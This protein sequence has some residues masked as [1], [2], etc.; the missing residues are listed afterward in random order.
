MSPGLGDQSRKRP[1]SS[2]SNDALH[3]PSPQRVSAN[4]STDHRPILPYLPSSDYRRHDSG[5]PNYLVVRPAE[6]MAY[7]EV[8]GEMERPQSPPGPVLDTVPEIE[9][10]AF[11]R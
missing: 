4:F 11:N 3:T 7:Q 5:D 8:N 1:F 2:V 10:A 9:D 6:P